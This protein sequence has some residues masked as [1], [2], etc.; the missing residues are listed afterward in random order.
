MKG[1]IIGSDFIE[2]GDS[3]KILEINTNTTI[4]N[5]AVDLLDFDP[6]FAFL[7]QANINELHFIYNISESYIPTNTDIFAFEEK[8]KEICVTNDIQYFGYTVP[9]NSVTVPY[10]E[11][12]PNK[13][14]L[15]Q[16]FDTT[17]LIDETYCA[18][19]FEFLKLM[20]GSDLIPNTY[21][22]DS[23][24]GVDGL[25]GLTENGVNVPNVLVKY[26]YPDYDQKEYPAIYGFTNEEELDDLKSTLG[27]NYIAQEFVY[28]EANL[29]EGRWSTIRTIDIVYGPELDIINLGGY[30]QSTALP[31]GYYENE[32]VEGTK[33]YNQRTRYTYINKVNGNF[34]DVTYHVDDDSNIMTADGTLKKIGDL[35]VN[36]ALKTVDFTDLN[37]IG[38]SSGDES[39]ESWD[40]TFDKT[41][42]TITN[43]ETNIKIINSADVKTIFIR[44]TLENG[45]TWVDSPYSTFYFE[46]KDS[47]STRWDMLNK[48]YVGDKIILKNGSTGELTKVAVTG[49]SMEYFEKKVYE[50]DV[51]PYDTFLSEVSQD[52]YVIMHNNCECCGWSFCGNWC[53]Y[54]YCPVCDFG[55]PPTKF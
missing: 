51:E 9:Q 5:D 31:I 38:A 40:G 16:A 19:K 14:I 48:M 37:G 21:F 17:A 50:L 26:R 54:P 39:F 6:F 52:T 7:T 12:A 46:E 41:V 33:K 10:I 45:L 49:L 55:L 4:Q 22:N 44:I 42:E 34:Y 32:F 29:V 43:V 3:V 23:L 18:D 24:L 35:L 11:D 53:C 28:D 13:F 2:K 15:R 47:T 27:V 30:R 8:L 1:I 20:E 25:T 36:D